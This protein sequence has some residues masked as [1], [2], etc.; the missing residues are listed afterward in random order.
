M[1]SVMTTDLG[2]HWWHGWAHI[3]D[4]WQR[5]AVAEDVGTCHRLLLAATEGMRLSSADR[6]LVLG[7]QPPAPRRPKENTKSM[8][9][10][11]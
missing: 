11:S 9:K 8:E 1:T 10:T 7:T 5:L 6:F 4:R 3:G 2:L